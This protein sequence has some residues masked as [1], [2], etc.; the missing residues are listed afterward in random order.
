MDGLLGRLVLQGREHVHV[1]L[2]TVRPDSSNLVCLHNFVML[3]WVEIVLDMNRAF[4]HDLGAKEW[5]GSGR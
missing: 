3:E 5:I 1:A 2:A 4:L